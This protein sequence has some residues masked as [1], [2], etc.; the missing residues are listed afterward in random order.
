MRLLVVAL[1]L[2]SAPA[3]AQTADSLAVPVDS[4]AVEDTLLVVEAPP[5]A[6]TV[7]VPPPQPTAFRSPGTGL[8]VVLPVGWDGPAAV[9]ESRLPGYAL[10]TFTTADGDLAL[11]VERVVGLSPLDRQRWRLGQTPYGYHGLR[12]TGPATTAIAGTAFDLA[13][14][15][16]GGLVVF[17]QSGETF[18]TVHVQAPASVWAAHRAQALA[19]LGGIRL[20]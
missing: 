9:D 7:E 6:P 12:P 4:S 2:A 5:E 20:P 13:G 1:A 8:H 15:G 16:V 3:I 14:A 17:A 11:R 19:V 18:W 10:Y